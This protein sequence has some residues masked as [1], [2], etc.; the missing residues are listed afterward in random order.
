MNVCDKEH[1]TIQYA[2]LSSVFSLT[3]RL[4]GAA[5]GFGA[6][7]FG[8]GDY[9]A[10]TFFVSLPAFLLLPWV[11]GWIH[12]PRELKNAGLP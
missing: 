12:E 7:R 6:E 5:S 8:Y 1:A 3:G 4:V 9:F 10:L 2:F 11:K